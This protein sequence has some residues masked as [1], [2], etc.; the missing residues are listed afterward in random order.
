MDDTLFQLKFTTKQLERFAKKCEKDEVVQ[1]NKVRKALTQGNVEGARIYAENA[2]RKKNEGLN[3]LRMAS[4]VDAVASKVQT[5]VSMKQVT[6]NM[7]GVVKGLDKAMQTMDLQKVTATME[8]FEKV[9]ENLDVHTQT[10]EDSMG[11]ATTLTTPT[12]QVDT[13]IQ[14]VAEENGLEVMSQL[15]NARPSTDSISAGSLSNKE[16]DALSRRLAQ[17]RN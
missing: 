7:S 5:A 12:D 3:Y 1:K 14:Q 4:R 2:I 13:L 10:M 9:F 16:G 15:E 11:N 17:L 6:R 8:K